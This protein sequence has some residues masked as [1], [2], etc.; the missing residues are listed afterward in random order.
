MAEQ[1][2]KGDDR[3]LK[4]GDP[5]KAVP[6]APPGGVPS[7]WLPTSGECQQEQV[8]RQAGHSGALRGQKS[9]VFADP[10]A[11]G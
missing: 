8:A 4:S 9:H 3:R 7:G 1:A 6:A 10:V 11:L 2:W 5:G